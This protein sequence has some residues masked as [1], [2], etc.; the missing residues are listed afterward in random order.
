MYILLQ[1]GREAVRRLT[2]KCNLT[3]FESLRRTYTHE[4]TYSL[5]EGRALLK[6]QY[7]PASRSNH[8]K[9]KL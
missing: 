3:C 2:D 6:T 8:D 4:N 7:S 1:L 9:V 5:S